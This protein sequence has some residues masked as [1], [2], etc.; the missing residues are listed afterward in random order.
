MM[1]LLMMV[2]LSAL[3]RYWQ[4]KR[5]CVD[6]A[7]DFV[8]AVDFVTA[9][10]HC[11][12]PRNGSVHPPLHMQQAY[13]QDYHD[14]TEMNKIRYLSK[15]THQTGLFDSEYR[16]CDAIDQKSALSLLIGLNA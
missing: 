1:L 10:D 14:S 16:M 2:L 9:V 8:V 11:W 13:H 5:F 6:S 12:G 15:S 4:Q 3:V 7:G